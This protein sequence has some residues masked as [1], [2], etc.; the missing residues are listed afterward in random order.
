MYLLYQEL[1]VNIRNIVMQMKFFVRFLTFF[2]LFCLLRP[3]IIILRH[4]K[5][6]RQFFEMIFL[7]CE[8]F[9]I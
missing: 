6:V 8:E 5:G 1:N 3:L 7:C 4:K 2:S 9:V